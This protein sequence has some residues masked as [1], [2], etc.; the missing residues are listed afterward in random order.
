M[1]VACSGDSPVLQEEIQFHF[2]HG[3]KKAVHPVFI[4]FFS[5]A[6]IPVFQ[7]EFPVYGEQVHVLILRGGKPGK[8]VDSHYIDTDILSPGIPDP[9]D[10]FQ[11]FPQKLLGSE[12]L[13]AAAESFDLGKGMIQRFHAYRHGIGIVDNP[14]FGTKFFNGTGNFLK[15]GNHAQR[16]DQAAGA[17]SI[18]YGLVNT[19]FFRRMHIAFHLI[20]GAGY[21]GNHHKVRSF[22]RITDGIHRLVI[23]WGSA[24]R[25]LLHLISNHFVFTGGLPVNIIQIYASAHV[26]RRGQITH[27]PPCPSPGTS[28]YICDLDIFRPVVYIPHTVP[29]SVCCNSTSYSTILARNN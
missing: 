10:I 14:G 18:S 29:P 28:S 15:H 4:C 3:I 27:K 7:G 11:R 6:G 13:M 22:K 24:V 8:V 9:C 23:P 16:P 2:F 25:K 21:D 1:P 5:E 26:I 12:N 20:K 19:V 17:C